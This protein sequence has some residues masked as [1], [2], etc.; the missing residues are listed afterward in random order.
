MD[1]SEV[2]SRIVAAYEAGEVITS[3]AWCGRIT[4]DGEWVEPPRAALEAINGHNVLAHSICPE[5]S[6]YLAAHP[7]PP[8]QGRDTGGTDDEHGVSS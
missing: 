5:C 7:V 6:A 2:T 8:P 3:C 4:L 1:P